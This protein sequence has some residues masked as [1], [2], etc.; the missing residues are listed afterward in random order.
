[1]NYH[2]PVLVDKLTSLY[3]D[4]NHRL[5]IDGTL[6]NGG[7]SLAFTK[8]GATVYG[9]D[10]DP[11][12]LD[13]AKNRITTNNPQAKF[14]PILDNYSR[15]SHI[16][17]DY[18]KQP[19]D[20]ILFDLGLSIN[21]IKSQGR[22]FSFDDSISLDMTINPNQKITAQT[23]V[24]HY[25]QDQLFQ[26]FSKNAQER[27]ALDIAQAIVT[28]R[29]KELFTNSRQL[30]DLIVSIYQQHHYSSSIHPAT[31][32]FLALKMEVN[33]DLANITL[34]FNQSLKLLKPK[35]YLAIITFHSTEDRLVKRLFQ[36][37][38]TANVFKRTF[39]I[40]PNHQDIL[41]NHLCRSAI[42]R[43]GQLS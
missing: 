43:I 16:Y 40:K 3:S 26:L 39:K 6:G 22:G 23:I 31:K 11:T 8:L 25:S 34:A 38:Q 4:F 21:Q 35:A 12:N 7:H 18:I 29:K 24:N 28:L 14:T 1:M 30:A 15:I 5:V 2:Q 10:K 36:S 42:L 19:V 41:D 17:A 20:L 9:I 32:A 13:I 27:F 33:Q 37:A